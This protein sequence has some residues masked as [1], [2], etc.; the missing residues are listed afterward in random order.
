MS[1]N[2]QEHGHR[3]RYRLLAMMFVLVTAAN[4][5]VVTTASGSVTSRKV[6]HHVRKVHPH[7]AH[8]AALRSHA[9][10][11]PHFSGTA[12]P[13]QVPPAGEAYLGGWV[14]PFSQGRSSTNVGTEF[15]ELGNFQAEFGR[16]L[17]MVHVYQAWAQPADNSLLAAI[18]N[19]GAV[20]VIDWACPTTATGPSSSGSTTDIASGTDT[21]TN[22]YIMAYAKELAAFGRPVF[23][24]WLWEFNITGANWYQDC[25]QQ[26]S[27]PVPSVD[28]PVFITAWQDIYNDFQSAGATNVSFVWNPGMAGNTSSAFLTSFFPGQQYVNWVGIDGYSRQNAIQGGSIQANP[29]FTQLFQTVYC[30]IEGCGAFGSNPAVTGIAQGMGLPMMI[31]ETGTTN[32]PGSTVLEEHQA[33]YLQSALTALSNASPS[34]NGGLFSAIRALSYFD[35]D[36]Y[37]A[38]DTTDDDIGDW[39]L[40]TQPY[41]PGELTGFP[42]F[43]ALGQSSYFSFMDPQ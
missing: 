15:A 32:Q 12:E 10:V 41:A 18:A 35:A 11:R 42:A 20:P 22:N 34:S 5:M 40:T 25:I 29:S 19:T 7:K 4:V 39:T 1:P 43:T 28:G 33:L 24:R 9:A 14:Q 38:Q 27:R 31:G 16:P 21:A 36:Y 6:H 2:H 17:A 37:N 26:G 23:L 30:T 8:H 3:R 13:P